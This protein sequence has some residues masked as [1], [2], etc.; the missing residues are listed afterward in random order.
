MKPFDDYPG[1][2]RELL[3]PLPHALSPNPLA[4]ALDLQFVTGQRRCAYCGGSLFGEF[5]CSLP[6]L[7]HVV[8]V[9]DADRL[10]IPREYS[11]D[12]INAVLCCSACRELAQYYSVGDDLRPRKLSVESFVSLRDSVFSERKALAAQ[13]P[14]EEMIA[15]PMELWDLS[16]A[17]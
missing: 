3:G 5:S 16:E 15:V 8:P 17:A 13:R 11:R 14:D 9:A 7:D 1:G 4:P 6:Q 12:M 2:G 10:G